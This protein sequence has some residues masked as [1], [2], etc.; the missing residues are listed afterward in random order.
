MVTEG[1][2][3][4]GLEEGGRPGPW[5]HGPSMGSDPIHPTIRPTSLA[6]DKHSRL[7]KYS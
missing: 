4:E 1:S 5:C 7:E 3:L 2:L 6:G